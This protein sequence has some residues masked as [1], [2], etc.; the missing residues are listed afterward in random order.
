[1]IE[2]CMMTISRQTMNRFLD[3]LVKKG[4]LSK[5]RNPKYKWDRTSQYRVNLIKIQQDLQNI[6][7]SLEGYSLL[8]DVSNHQENDNEP[9]NVQNG[10][11]LLEITT[12]TI[13]R[14]KKEEEK[15][16]RKKNKHIAYDLLNDFL[17]AKRIDQE[18]I[19]K[20]VTGIREM[21]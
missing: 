11:A 2:D 10:R 19:D 13:N 3:A 6:G 16:T 8:N 7:Y 1:M 9:S 21:S 15:N 5:R 12:E 17:K 18:T 14:D 20:R 4:W